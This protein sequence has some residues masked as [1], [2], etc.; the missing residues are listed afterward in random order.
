MTSSPEGEEIVA[1]EDGKHNTID[2][3][4]TDE[5]FGSKAQL[6]AQNGSDSEEDAESQSD[7]S[8]G[9]N[10]D[11]DGSED[12]NNGGMSAYEK[13]RLERIKRN[14]LRLKELGLASKEGGGILGKKKPKHRRK[15][16]STTN[17]STPAVP[18][19]R[20]RRSTG[21]NVSYV[22]PSLRDVLNNS[23]QKLPHSTP[24][25]AV[26][27]VE[28]LPSKPK[29]CRPVK[30]VRNQR[31][32]RFIYD[33]MKRIEKHKKRMLKEAEKNRKSAETESKYWQKR[34]SMKEKRVQKAIESERNLK[35][36]QVEYALYGTTAKSFVNYLDRRSMEI[37]A[38]IRL[39]DSSRMV[40]SVWRGVA[41]EC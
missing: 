31:M 29:N 37:G 36:Q 38:K 12:E 10:S 40:R 9:S 20:S 14:N 21:Q 11:S 30:D 23:D 16:K 7:S 6:G 26:D 28:E 19:R 22:E 35:Q 4:E 27:G 39:Y 41:C 5:D 8:S 17:E 34:A 15:S 18:Q 1:R 24:I 33:E 32:A 3:S 13:L 2:A 25:L